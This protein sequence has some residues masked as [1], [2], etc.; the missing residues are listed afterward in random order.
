[1]KVP[2]QEVQEWELLQEDV[3]E[4]EIVKIEERPT[5][6]GDSLSWEF[7]LLDEG[8]EDRR[9]WGMTSQNLVK[10]DRCKL[11]GWLQ[12]I[13]IDLEEGQELE[14]DELA[15]K[16]CRVLVENYEGTDKIMRSRVKEI[17]ATKR[18]QEKT[19]LASQRELQLLRE[20]FKSIGFTESVDKVVFINE[21]GIK[22][23]PAKLESKDVAQILRAIETEVQDKQADKDIEELPDEIPF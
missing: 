20:G 12:A 15:G 10:L 19:K 1:M 11:W 17:L 3:Y 22:N 8:V 18:K 14:T 16:P 13:G 21:L 4:A 5:K 2:M 6:Y 23:S 9:V 7:V